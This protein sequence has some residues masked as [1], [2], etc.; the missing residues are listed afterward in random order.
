[1]VYPPMLNAGTVIGGF[2]I[3]VQ[4]VGDDLYQ[5]VIP[6]TKLT[7]A[8]DKFAVVQLVRQAMQVIEDNWNKNHGNGQKVKII[9]CDPNIN[10]FVFAG[11]SWRVEEVQPYGKGYY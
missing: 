6:M 2:G 7:E 5:A 10:D 1:M 9:S 11:K 8:P 4:L 3:V